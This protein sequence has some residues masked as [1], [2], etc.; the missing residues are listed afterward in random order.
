MKAN[1]FRDN[2]Q[3]SYYMPYSIYLEWAFALMTLFNKISF[4][5]LCD[6]KYS[7]KYQSFGV[8]LPTCSHHNL[9]FL[10]SF[11]LFYFFIFGKNY[12]LK[13][14]YVQFNIVGKCINILVLI[15]HSFLSSYRSYK[16]KKVI[17]TMEVFCQHIHLSLWT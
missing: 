16:L 8:M 13:V 17:H 7:Y 1:S 6:L 2:I 3:Q 4:P 10:F 14:K 11:S 5:F 15:K 12:Y 9:A